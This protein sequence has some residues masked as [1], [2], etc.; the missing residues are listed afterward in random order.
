MTAAGRSGFLVGRCPGRMAGVVLM[1][2]P[3]ARLNFS[4]FRLYFLASGSAEVV[5]CQRAPN[6]LVG[7]IRPFLGDTGG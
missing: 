3:S 2:L 1:C 5:Q 6:K 7:A 4:S